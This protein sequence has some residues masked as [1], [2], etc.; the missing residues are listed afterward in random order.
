MPKMK[1]G[2]NEWVDIPFDPEYIAGLL[3]NG[4]EVFPDE[5]AN[6]DVEQNLINQSLRKLWGD[7]TLRTVPGRNEQTSKDFGWEQ[8]FRWKDTLPTPKS[9]DFMQVLPNPGVLYRMPMLQN[10]PNPPGM[11]EAKGEEPIQG[12]SGDGLKYLTG[13]QAVTK[14][15]NLLG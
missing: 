9:T 12:L 11:L 3:Y 5:G 13:E 10:N 8:D 1:I 6:L 14:K 7:Q 15:K 2:K 4:L